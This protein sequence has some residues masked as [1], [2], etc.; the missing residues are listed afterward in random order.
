MGR[1]IERGLINFLSRKRG[2]GGGY[3]RVGDYLRGGVN[4]G[5]TV[6]VGS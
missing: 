2:G 1:L 6:T 5:F 3:W 4:R